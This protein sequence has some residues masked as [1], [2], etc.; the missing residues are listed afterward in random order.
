MGDAACDW[1]AA[2]TQEMSERQALELEFPPAAADGAFFDFLLPPIP[3]L[4]APWMQMRSG[5]TAPEAVRALGGGN[6]HPT[7]EA[8]KWAD[9]LGHGVQAGIVAGAAVTLAVCVVR[10]LIR[11]GGR[12]QLRSADKRLR[13]GG[14]STSRGAVRR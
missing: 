13:V 12:L 6:S 11:L 5:G 3:R 14:G 10:L 9:A 4:E 7:V 8:P 2:G 1:V